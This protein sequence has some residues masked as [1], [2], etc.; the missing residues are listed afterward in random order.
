M[1][2]TKQWH[3]VSG[4]VATLLLLLAAMPSAQAQAPAS[5]ATKATIRATAPVVRPAPKLPCYCRPGH[6]HMANCPGNPHFRHTH[7]PLTACCTCSCSPAPTPT[8]MPQGSNPRRDFLPS[9]FCITALALPTVSVVY[10][11]GASDVLRSCPI[12]VPKRPPRAA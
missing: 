9:F 1:F 3:W 10:P 5:V 2:R 12:M 4:V 6:C 8:A 11:P 7:F